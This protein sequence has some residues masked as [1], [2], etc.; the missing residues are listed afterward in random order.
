MG[1]YRTTA[2][3]AHPVSRK[4][5]RSKQRRTGT[6][7]L[8]I[9]AAITTAAML[10]RVNRRVPA[11]GYVTSADYAEVR[12]SV[13]GTVRKILKSS[14]AQVTAGDLLVQ[15]EDAHERAAMHESENELHKA[16]AELALREAELAELKRI[17]EHSI[18]TA[19]MSVAHAEEKL[20]LTRELSSRGLT[21]GRTVSEDAFT[22][23]QTKAHLANLLAADATLDARR[24]EVLRR[25]LDIK[26]DAV[27]RTQ[28]RVEERR[29]CAPISGRLN[30][31]TFYEGEVVRPD[32]VLYEVYGGPAEILKLQVPERYATQ[33]KS[34]QLC[35]AELQTYA[36]TIGTRWF[37]GRVVHMRDVIQS[38]NQKTYRVIYC[39]FDDQDL[40]IPPGTT[41]DVHIYVGRSPLWAA[42][43]GI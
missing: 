4:E 22:V 34:N 25:T 3:E 32:N 36:N 2:G 12:A 24:V 43:L 28:A 13:S 21:S 8:L 38:Q 5:R 19:R 18:T 23:E 35:R 15:L 7:V 29:V 9:L 37:H 17:H 20:T 1:E 11:K 40:D 31:F 16:E 27:S 41:A 30:R 14:G 33:I 26:R 10:V 6:I 42:L 39:T